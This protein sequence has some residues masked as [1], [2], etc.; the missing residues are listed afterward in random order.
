MI[1]LIGTL[2]LPVAALALVSVS[3]CAS[4]AALNDNDQ[5]VIP[6]IDVSF[7]V[8]YIPGHTVGHIAYYREGMLFCGDT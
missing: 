8:M 3:T 2:S 5:V 1:A 6:E 4:S 7:N